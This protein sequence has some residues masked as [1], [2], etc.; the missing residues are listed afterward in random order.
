MGTQTQVNRAIAKGLAAGKMGP[1]TGYICL[2]SQRL[3]RALQDAVTAAAGDL[4]IVEL[5]TI[6]SACRWERFALWAQRELRRRAD[7]LSADQRLAYARATCT[8]SSERDKCI[9]SLR[10]DR[11]KA[12]KV[13]DLLY[14]SPLPFSGPVGADGSKDQ[15]DGQHATAGHPGDVAGDG[16]NSGADGKGGDE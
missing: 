6:Q 5:A 4:G 16:D 12:G 1:G 7:E 3:E 2:L 9:K 11:D 8:G 14:A 15:G 13:F 10:L